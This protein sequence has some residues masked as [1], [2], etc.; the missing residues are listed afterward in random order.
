MASLLNLSRTAKSPDAPR[1]G[2]ASHQKRRGPAGRH[3][4]KAGHACLR[5][6]LS[7]DDEIIAINDY[8]LVPSNSMPPRR[9]PAGEKS[10]C[11]SR[12]LINFFDR[13]HLGRD[14]GDPWKLIVKKTRLP[15]NRTESLAWRFSAITTA[16]R[17]LRS[18]RSLS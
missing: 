10:H 6:G 8:R 15:S 2:S 5:L 13:S 3:P 9:Y 11:S 18:R 14:P 4:G 16:S 17:P 1:G 7:P 12:A